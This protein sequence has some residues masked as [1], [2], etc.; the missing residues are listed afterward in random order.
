[1]TT[2]RCP[3]CGGAT[4]DG[5]PVV[6]GGTIM[7]RGAEVQVQEGA[8]N[9]LVALWASMP[10]IVPYDELY[11][12]LYAGRRSLLPKPTILT[13]YVRRLRQ[14]LDPL[15]LFIVTERNIGYGLTLDGT[16]IEA[17][18]RAAVIP[19]RGRTPIWNRCDDPRLRRLAAAG[20]SFVDIKLHFPWSNYVQLYKRMIRLRL[21]PQGRRRRG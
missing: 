9:L 20:M 15:G 21:D 8:A 10:R 16:D 11:H 2:I 3:T 7:F 13:V 6:S 17:R 1:M 5:K 4:D 18:R 19:Q 14:A 12:R